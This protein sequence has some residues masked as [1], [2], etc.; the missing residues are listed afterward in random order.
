MT[1]L[2]DRDGDQMIETGM[3]GRWEF[4]EHTADVA[5]VAYGA[6][7]PTLFASAGLGLFDL[8]VETGAATGEPKRGREDVARR[9]E[10]A[11]TDLPDL[12]VTWLNELL[13]LFEVEGVVFT[14][15]QVSLD[16]TSRLAGMG[17]GEKLDP[18][19]HAVKVGVKAATY[20]Q[21]AVEREAR[22]DGPRWRAQVILDV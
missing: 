7:L 22:R 10:V 20:H 3:E 19:R 15:F 12:L 13:Y 1:E 21:V 8:M 17:Y 2:S 11:A 5:L 9:I 18:K 4:A 14:R 6:D 16:G